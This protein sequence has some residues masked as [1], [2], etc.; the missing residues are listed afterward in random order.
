MIKVK[1]ILLVLS[2]LVS[3]SVLANDEHVVSIDSL[4]IYLDKN[5]FPTVIVENDISGKFNT[6][7][8]ENWKKDDTNNGDGII[9]SK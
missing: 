7:N 5:N 8:I 1:K 4:K 9:R 3:L 6:C 2:S